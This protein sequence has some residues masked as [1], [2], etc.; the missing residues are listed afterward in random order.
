MTDYFFLR[1]G[2]RGFSDAPGVNRA[3]D[4]PPGTET[5]CQGLLLLLA[6]A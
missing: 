4:T 2:R 5:M 3:Y 6:A 1:Y